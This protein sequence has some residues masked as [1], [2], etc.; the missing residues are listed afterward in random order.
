MA[1][2]QVVEAGAGA[3]V[4]AGGGAGPRSGTEAGSGVR[5]LLP[6]TG[7]SELGAAGQP[8]QAGGPGGQVV[9]VAQPA[10]EPRWSLVAAA[11]G[12]PLL[13]DAGEAPDGQGDDPGDD[14][15]TDDDEPG[16]GGVGVLHGRP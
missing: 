4:G 10:R 3:G 16:R 14:E 1:D 12:G 6:V 15:H 5:P 13:L 11:V 9:A 8:G 2:H 7:E